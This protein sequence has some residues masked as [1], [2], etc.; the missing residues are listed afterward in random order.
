MEQ[1]CL[2][3]QRRQSGVEIIANDMI[4]MMSTHFDS[5]YKAP[6]C[7][8]LDYTVEGILSQSLEDWTVVDIGDE[9]FE[10]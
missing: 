8:A 9:T 3:L 4:R 10:P 2:G 7:W 5:P 1:Q 6:A